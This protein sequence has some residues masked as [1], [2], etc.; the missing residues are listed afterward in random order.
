MV[1]VPF[2]GSVALGHLVE[3]LA[4]IDGVDAIEKV[5]GIEGQFATTRNTPLRR[6]RTS[7]R[8]HA[9]DPAAIS[10]L[11]YQFQDSRM[12]L[13][14]RGDLCRSPRESDGVMIKIFNS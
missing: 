6:D 2:L 12:Q 9:R 14:Y 13:P 5:A 11:W 4:V 8:V 3:F 10:S 1:V 7:H